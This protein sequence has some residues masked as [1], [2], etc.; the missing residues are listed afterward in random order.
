MPKHTKAFSCNLKP[1]NDVLNTDV[2]IIYQHLENVNMQFHVNAKQLDAVN[3][4]C[5]VNG[6]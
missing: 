1:V 6:Y 4:F 2:V 5:S 3:I